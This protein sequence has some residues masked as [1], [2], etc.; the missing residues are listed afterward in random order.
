MKITVKFN[1]I[2]RAEEF[3]KSEIIVGRPN[4]YIPPDLDLTPDITVSRTHAR[5]YE[6]DGWFWIEDLAS[7]Y[8]SLVNGVKQEV[9]RRLNPG[10]AIR[11]GETDLTVA[12][13]P[14][15]KREETTPAAASREAQPTAEPLPLPP[16][17][18]APDTQ[19]SPAEAAGSIRVDSELGL[20]DVSL[21]QVAENPGFTRQRLGLLLELPMQFALKQDVKS[22][23][24]HTIDKAVGVMRGADRG[25]AV[26]R[27]RDNNQLDVVAW[28]GSGQPAVSSS[29]CFKAMSEGRALIWRR[30]AD[31]V[32]SESMH[33]LE[34]ET[35][36]CAP[37]IWQDRAIGV[38]CVGNP[39]RDCLFTEDELQFL[40]AVANYA[41]MA[42]ANFRL[43]EGP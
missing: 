2:E 13:P 11:I 6:R 43:C 10:D 38:L 7:K 34:I 1:G 37:M 17:L 14:D 41:A 21:L 31:G 26:L 3:D 23:L 35:G 39:K 4:P 30:I 24:Q 33:R 5:I 28:S 36:M 32:S 22:V 8:G 25:G 20:A 27:N 18:G 15:F 40:V 42:V 12:Y 16:G 9:K 19:D 29:L